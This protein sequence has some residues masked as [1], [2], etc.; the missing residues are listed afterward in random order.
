MA[1][2]WT[3]DRCVEVQRVPKTSNSWSIT[4]T[5]KPK[6]CYTIRP[7]PRA[8]QLLPLQTMITSHRF[9]LVCAFLAVPAIGRADDDFE[10]SPINYS[11]ATPDNPIARLQA[12]LNVGKAKMA[13]HQDHGYLPALLKALQISESSQ[14][15]VFSKTSL[16]RSRISPKSPRA[17]YFNDDMYIGYCQAAPVLEISAVDPK[18]GTVFYTL[19]QTE[20]ERPTFVRQTDSCLLCHAS[21]QT[22]NVPGH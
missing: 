7:T 19:E 15:L 10:R 13:Y 12:Q 21:S 17:L 18:L 8:Q 14:T 4:H 6:A 1:R 11:K 3:A 5:L 22:K 2:H 9:L 16:Q 20:V